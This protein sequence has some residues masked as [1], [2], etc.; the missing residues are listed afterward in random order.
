MHSAI[1]VFSKNPEFELPDLQME[2]EEVQKRNHCAD[3]I[4]DVYSNKDVEE[5]FLGDC[6]LKKI[7]PGSLV[8]YKLGRLHVSED[9]SV[10]YEEWALTRLQR[11]R[12][13][14]DK[15][16]EKSSLGMIEYFMRETN[17]I[18]ESD[19]EEDWHVTDYLFCI[20]HD[21]YVYIH[22]YTSFIDALL[23]DKNETF[24]LIGAYDYH[25]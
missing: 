21:D 24:Y 16:I 3:Y 9:I 6:Y 20:A 13:W 18:T 5:Y 15:Q 11:I 23:H 8:D 25:F 17:V 14:Q 4:G 10:E 7:L 22:D 12:K 19:N 2:L 1:L